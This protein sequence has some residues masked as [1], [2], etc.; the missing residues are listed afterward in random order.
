MNEGIAFGLFQ[1]GGSLKN[2]FLIFITSIATI[3]LLFFHFRMKNPTG[4]KTILLALVFGGAIGNL[5]DRI[6]RGYVVDFID[7]YIK[8]FHW[9]VFNL[10]DTYISI[11]LIIIFY[12]QIFKKEHIF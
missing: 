7:V 3:M 5:Y 9:P 12:L 4:L 11:G 6:F 1:D 8:N 2:Y 10:A